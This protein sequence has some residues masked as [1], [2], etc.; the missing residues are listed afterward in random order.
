[1]ATNHAVTR[2]AVVRAP[3]GPESIDIVEVPIA[4]PGP[5]QIRVAIAAAAINPVDLG[6]ASG[7]FH[8]LG[9]V[10]QPDY[11]GLGWDFAGTVDAAGDGVGVPVGARVAG[12]IDGF[13]RDYGSHAEHIVIPA[14][15][16]ALVPNG[17]DLT[18]AAAV[19]L[20]V[21]AAAQLIDILGD[22]PIGTRRLLVTGAAGAVG[23]YAAVLAKHRGWQVTGLARSTDEQF[24]RSIGVDFTAAAVPGWDAVADAAAMQG[25]GLELVRDGGRFIGVQPALRLPEARGI[26]VDVVVSHPDGPLLANLLKRVV[27]GELSARVHASLPLDDVVEGY[28]RLAKGGVRGQIVIV[29]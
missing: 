29:P 24:V 28:Q 10:H 2:R 6:V 21:T 12:F 16:V 11:T 17:M 20:T 8:E 1:M 9:M 3:F 5:G 7:R 26:A 19:P 15:N 13:D 25:A 27:T 18:E 14:A 4:T 22:A 23:S